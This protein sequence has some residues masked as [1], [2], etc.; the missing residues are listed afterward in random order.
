MCPMKKNG[1]LQE[2]WFWDVLINY[3]IASHVLHFSDEKIRPLDRSDL[4]IR[5]L[6]IRVKDL[7]IG[8]IF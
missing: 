4:Y 2:T 7:I 3:I 1:F 8:K 5:D 6:F